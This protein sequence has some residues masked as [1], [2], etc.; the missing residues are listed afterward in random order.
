MS[1]TIYN[2]HLL[3]ADLCTICTYPL[4]FQESFFLFTCKFCHTFHLMD[5]FLTSASPIMH[6]RQIVQQFLLFFFI[7]HTA[8]LSGLVSTDP[9]YPHFSGHIQPP[10]PFHSGPLASSSHPYPTGHFFRCITVLSSLLKCLLLPYT[11]SLFSYLY[12]TIISHQFLQYS[13][14]SHTPHPIT[15]ILPSFLNTLWESY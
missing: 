9:E 5:K 12:S 6:T 13:I 7:L 2:F 15:S 14:S 8:E 10:F 11:Y 4:L 3:Y 1:F